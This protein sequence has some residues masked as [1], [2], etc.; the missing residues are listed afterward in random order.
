MVNLKPVAA[1]TY[2]FYHEERGSHHQKIGKI[3]GT[4]RYLMGKYGKTNNRINRWEIWWDVQP[5]MGI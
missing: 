2:D 5:K 4:W 1:G 3:Y